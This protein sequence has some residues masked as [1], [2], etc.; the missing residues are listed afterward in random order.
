MYDRKWSKV[1]APLRLGI[2][3]KII[4]VV[5]VISIKYDKR[6]IFSYYLPFITIV[7]HSGNAPDYVHDNLRVT[8]A[9]IIELRDRGTFGFLLPPDQ[10][11]PTSM[12]T[13][14]GIMAGVFG[15]KNVNN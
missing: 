2:T 8:N 6:V 4:Q 7:A 3:L 1:Y 13:L 10:I 12:E 14:D 11:K 15:I 5:D 9:Y